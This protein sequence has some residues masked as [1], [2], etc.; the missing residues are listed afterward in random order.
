M[1]A[2]LDA[3]IVVARTRRGYAGERVPSAVRAVAESKGTWRAWLICSQCMMCALAGP[4]GAVPKYASRKKVEF[5]PVYAAW[6][7]DIFSSRWRRIIPGGSILS[8]WSAFRER[9]SP[10]DEA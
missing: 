7:S 5:G 2:R 1:N 10:A 9:L 3:R 4:A 6:R 8:R